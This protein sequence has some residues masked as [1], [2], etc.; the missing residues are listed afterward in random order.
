MF[1]A[2]VQVQL[3]EKAKAFAVRVRCTRMNKFIVY[4][5]FAGVGESN[6][7]TLRNALRSSLLLLTDVRSLRLAA[8]QWL[9]AEAD[10]VMSETFMHMGLSMRKS[11][12][13]SCCTLTTFNSQYHIEDM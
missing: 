4:R 2:S 13:M 9:P 11:M 3:E 6:R 1:Q 12:K 10:A 7:G 8:A 5:L